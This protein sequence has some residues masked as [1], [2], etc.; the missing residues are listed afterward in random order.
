M[1]IDARQLE[2][3]TEIEAEVCIIGAG[4]AGITLALELDQ[5]GIKTCVLEGGGPEPDDATRDL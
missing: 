5:L 2:N 3:S 1:F 4:V